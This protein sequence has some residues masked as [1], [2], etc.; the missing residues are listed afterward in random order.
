[1][2]I[3]SSEDINMQILEWVENSK[4]LKELKAL[5]ME[6]RKALFGQIFTDPKPSGTNTYE[7]GGG[8]ELKAVTGEDYKVDKAA[9]HLIRNQMHEQLTPDQIQ[10]IDDCINWK[11]DL[12][13]K[14]YKALDP[15][16]KALFDEAITIKPRTVSMSLKVPK[17]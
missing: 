6:Q 7:L 16:A 8:Y 13:M 4:K 17:D 14:S 12:T 3:F 9:F 2:S 1:V 15:E 11:P 10:A 5:E